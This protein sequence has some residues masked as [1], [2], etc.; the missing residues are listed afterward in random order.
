MT[1]AFYR[2]WR[3]KNWDDVVG[4]SH[5][6]ETLQN[7]VRSSR[8]GHAYLFAGPRGTGKTSTARLLAKAVNC[9][10]EDL[11]KRPC[12]HC[13][14]C[15]AVNEGKLLDLIEIDAASNTSV[16]DVR[17][18]R[19]KINF[20]PTQGRYKIYIIDEVHMLSTAA[21]NA[22]L[23]TLEEPPSHAI[24]VLATT[25]IHKIPAT[26]LS[27]CQ[28][29]EFRRISVADITAYLDEIIAGENLSVDKEATALIARQST[30]AMRDAISLLDQLASTGEQ[31]SLAYAQNV[32]GT[33]T[34]QTVLEIV[35]AI[36]QGNAAE[37]LQAVHKTL[38][39]GA[40]PR[41]F[42]KQI[43]EYLRNVLL[44]AL[45]NTDTANQPGEIQERIGEHA[46]QFTRSQIIFCVER[47]NRVAAD[48]RG[49]WQPNLPLE[50]A[51]IEC[52]ENMQ[53]PE[54]AESA[55][56]EGS[57]IEQAAPETNKRPLK[58]EFAQDSGRN[59]APAPLPA[60]EEIHP[61][62]PEKNLPAAEAPPE[63][64]SESKT[65]DE[66]TE[67]S[68]SLSLIR[69]NWDNVRKTVR[70][71]SPQ[72]EGLLNS[73]KSIS[74]KDS[75]LLLGF[76]SELV[77]SKMEANEHLDLVRRVILDILKVDVSIRCVVVNKNVMTSSASDSLEGDSMVN[78]A[79]NL[80]GQIVQ[81]D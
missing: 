74:I 11:S 64:K 46:R 54:A 41:Q 7:A 44:A 47:F 33:A 28:R 19:D 25:E 26:V 52:I 12:N 43:V 66:E 76:A 31:I 75:D 2:K 1:Q 15:E 3:P 60:A 20:S 81:K 48:T 23:K 14:L 30:G 35:D 61:Q 8:I 50:L 57:G 18:L 65:A 51:L 80:G 45:G 77:M 68:L 42:S 62:P 58:K 67:G 4:Q 21:F 55:V 40:D 17:S 13:A 9:L 36:Y 79:L 6:I 70:S 59:S 16:D 78:A 10:D 32:L 38:D 73:C 5:I 71:K 24:F 56:Q 39:G 27:R 34:S 29:H 37:G 53:K 72:T 49:N 63:V 69:E 22:L